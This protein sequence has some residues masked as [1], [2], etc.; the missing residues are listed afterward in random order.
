VLQVT[1]HGE[2]GV[3]QGGLLTEAYTLFFTT[4]VRR[5]VGLFECPHDDAHQNDARARRFY[6]PVKG[7]LP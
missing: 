3:D 7:R 2:A 6:L 5:E 4:V 1:F